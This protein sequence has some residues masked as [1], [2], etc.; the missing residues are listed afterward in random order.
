MT[1]YQAETEYL[2][3]SDRKYSQD[4]MDEIV[5]NLERIIDDKQ[6]EIEGLRYLLAEL[7]VNVDD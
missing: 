3:P 7:G 1:Y 5:T 2:Y 4:E 6:S